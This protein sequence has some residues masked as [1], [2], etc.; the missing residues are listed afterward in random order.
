MRAVRVDLAA[1][2]SVATANTTRSPERKIGNGALAALSVMRTHAR[3]MPE[4]T[5]TRA[6]SMSDAL[7]SDKLTP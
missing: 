6:S 2:M 5:T 1:S 3:T 4:A 7:P